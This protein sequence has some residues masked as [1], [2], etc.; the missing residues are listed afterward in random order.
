MKRKVLISPYQ[1]GGL[2]GVQK[3][4]DDFYQIIG[5]KPPDIQGLFYS[6][7]LQ[8]GIEKFVFPDIDESVIMLD[9]SSFLKK[10]SSFMDDDV[11]DEAKDMVDYLF[12]H[13]IPH[14]EEHEDIQKQLRILRNFLVELFYSMKKQ[15]SMAC[16]LGIPDLEK[17]QP[18]LP[19]DLYFLLRN[20]FQKFDTTSPALPVLRTSI[21]M[22][23]V[24]CFIDIIHSDIFAKYISAHSE[25]ECS[26]IPEQSALRNITEVGKSLNGSYKI[27]TQLKMLTIKILPVTAKIIDAV[28]GKLPGV[29]AD[30]SVNS[31][32]NLISTKKRIV[33]Y[34]FFPIVKEAI[35]TGAKELAKK[36]HL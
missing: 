34:D 5:S 36:E 9:K 2:H 18:I 8:G 20:L 19:F 1:L 4:N 11:Y 6:A 24:D 10:R 35:R 29:I 32:S 21:N 16:V 14:L 31:V 27:H 17:L 26:N 23:D 12:L 13:F 33:V 15:T 7:M 30:Y 28:F 3:A 25:L 22:S